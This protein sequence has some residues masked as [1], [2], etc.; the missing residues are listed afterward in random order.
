MQ[1]PLPVIETGLNLH[2]PLGC[3]AGCRTVS[4]V[5]PRQLQEKE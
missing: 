3:F 5:H 2:D 4:D 1:M